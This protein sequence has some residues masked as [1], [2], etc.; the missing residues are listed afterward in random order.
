M[1]IKTLKLNNFQNFKKEEVNFPSGVTLIRGE[2]GAGKSTLLR[3]IF[4]GLFISNMKKEAGDINSIDKLVKK[5]EEEARVELEFE[6]NNDV[7]TVVWE[8]EAKTEE[9]GTRSGSTKTC[10]LTSSSFEDGEVIDGVKDVVA[11]IE[12]LLGMT[13][14]SFVN[15]VYVQQDDL[16]R[17][18]AATPSERAEI[19]DSLLGLSDI[20]EYIDRM[21]KA[22]PAAH[23]V[24]EDAA[25]RQA[26]VQE[27]INGMKT[28]SELKDE[29]RQLSSEITEIKS[30]IDKKQ[31]KIDEW[32]G[33]LE[34]LNEKIETYN[35][36]HSEID[37]LESKVNE[38][39]SKRESFRDEVE[40]LSEKLEEKQNR[41]DTLESKIKDSDE[42]LESDV[43]SPESAKEA[44]GA[45]R[46]EISEKSNKKTELQSKINQSE[47][48][49]ERL[50]TKLEENRDD[51]ETIL[52][53][54]ETA[55]ERITQ[56]TSRVEELSAE[57]SEYEDALIKNAKEF[58]GESN[59]SGLP[60]KVE[61]KD[62]LNNLAYYVNE[63]D[64]CVEEFK[65]GLYDVLGSYDEL[66]ELENEKDV[67]ESKIEGME[68]RV[69]SLSESKTELK[70]EIDKLES[71]IS[72]Q[73]EHVESLQN[74]L[75]N[76]SEEIKTLESRRDKMEN[77][78]DAH[79]SKTTKESEISEIRSEIGSKNGRVSDLSEHI[80]QLEK[81]LNEKE[82]E[83][84]DLDIDELRERRDKTKAGIDSRREKIESLEDEVDELK[85][86]RSKIEEKIESLK[87]LEA[88]SEQL[89]E[90][91]NWADDLYGEFNR[92]I[93]AYE[94]AKSKLRRENIARLN[95]YVNE[96]FDEIYQNRSF[97]GVRIH[98]DYT[99]ELVRTDGE[100]IEPELSSGGE[101]AILNIALRAGVY[102]L[103][104]E[105]TDTGGAY[106]PP[107]IL[108]EPTTFLDKDHVSEIDGVMRKMREWNVEQV[109]VVSHEEGL[110]DSA[111][112]EIRVIK[113]DS[114]HSRIITG[115]EE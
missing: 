76:V 55:K 100:I 9:D 97:D 46:N 18:A 4:A 106:L 42:E 62:K 56:K 63:D 86:A 64:D 19:L 85:D 59:S 16:T 112:N 82:K 72:E 14:E 70:K 113:D 35:E 1:K 78:V 95:E 21:E 58:I 79:M 38:N 94:D 13:A 111:D 43:S 110:I 29:K 53:Q 11:E 60:E 81:Q 83:A 3:G 69:E 50:N 84:V 47:D 101:G 31:D 57:I 61:I 98:D 52:N 36:T 28:K 74:E 15:S 65:R 90:R 24:R 40:T 115:E 22:R 89:E 37:E 26:E 27:T 87:S 41:L 6:V 92:T 23:T 39:K 71:D 104:T 20:Q 51:L 10:K 114:G 102:K 45:V 105:R 2:N 93:E 91:R 96:L 67:L 66:R 32:S 103:I 73:E 99:I 12:N 7:Y 109:L 34:T 30:E 77:V 54:L 5:G 8:I 48:E 25:S 68:Y 80:E 49:L 75:D 17:L 108:D 44:L 33:T 88:R 107:F